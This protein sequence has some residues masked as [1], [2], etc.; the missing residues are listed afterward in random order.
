MLGLAAVSFA[1][2]LTGCALSAELDVN[3]L[4]CDQDRS[5]P[6]GESCSADGYCRDGAQASDAAIDGSASGYAS[7]ILADE[8]IL[9]ARLD[10]AADLVVGDSS[11]NDRDGVIIGAPVTV[12]GVAGS[13][14]VEFDGVDDRIQWND[15]PA[16]GLDGS[17]TIELWAKLVAPINTYPGLVRKGNPGASGYLIFYGASSQQL[18]FKRSDQQY[19]SEEALLDSSF[20]HL[21]VTYDEPAMELRWYVDGVLT[22]AYSGV[23][24][25]P[26]D[27]AELAVG[28]GDERGSHIIDEFALYDRALVGASVIEHHRMGSARRR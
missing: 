18:V 25:L 12:D 11:G 22:V 28:V 3:R 5:C 10:D 24:F 1:A 13:A 23:E 7:V 21:V 19:S 14:A 15:D 20:R 2:A 6:A 9:Y 26:D 4:R 16:I 27:G 8:P 17:F